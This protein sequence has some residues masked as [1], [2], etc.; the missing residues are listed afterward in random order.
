[1]HCYGF[2]STSPPSFTSVASLHSPLSPPSA[3]PSVPPLLTAIYHPPFVAG[4]VPSLP[5]FCVQLPPTRFSNRSHHLPPTTHR[6]HTVAKWIPGTRELPESTVGSIRP[7]LARVYIVDNPG[8]WRQGTGLPADQRCR[9]VRP[10]VHGLPN[11]VPRHFGSTGVYNGYKS[12]VI[13]SGLRGGTSSEFHMYDPRN[14]DFPKDS[15]CHCCCC[16]L[17][18]SVP[19]PD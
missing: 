18:P 6:L 13:T 11:A 10:D 17:S 12:R 19:K 2:A 3:H 4:F 14:P 9:S 7:T 8:Q 16:C 15:R 5:S 1:M